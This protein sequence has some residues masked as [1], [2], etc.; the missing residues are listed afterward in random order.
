MMRLKNHNLPLHKDFKFLVYHLNKSMWAD[1][2]KRA[3]K[4]ALPS[5]RKESMVVLGDNY[6]G[7][8][9]QCFTNG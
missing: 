3:K 9:T 8:C 7:T 4:L 5:V 2:E 6:K 1:I